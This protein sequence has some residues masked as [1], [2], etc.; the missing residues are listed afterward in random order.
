[1]Q[2]YYTRMLL[3]V[4]VLIYCGKTRKPAVADKSCI[5][6]LGDSITYGYLDPSASWTVM[7]SHLLK[8]PVVNAGI[9][10]DTLEN[11]YRRIDDDV[12]PLRPFLVIVT[13]G[14]N[15]AALGNSLEQ[16]QISVQRIEE[17]LEKSGSTVVIGVPVPIML[18]AA[19]K[20]LQPFRVWLQSRTK[21]TIPFYNVFWRDNRLLSELLSD[22]V[23]PDR[24]GN[25]LMAE[26]AEKT[27]K[28][29][30]GILPQSN[31]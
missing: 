11:M 23:H 15:D 21:P 8:V 28:K 24:R 12:L 2:F 16:M 25:Q 29:I 26:I 30:P 9:N 19:E 3:V 5:V 17:K 27:L 4:L 13:G 6:A 31:H 20:R 1:M 7:L 10:G 22:G 18:E 14:S